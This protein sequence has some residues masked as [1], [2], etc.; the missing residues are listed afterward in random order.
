MAKLLTVS[1]GGLVGQKRPKAPPAARH[2]RRRRRHRK[3]EKLPEA[4]RREDWVAHPQRGVLESGRQRGR[5]RGGSGGK[6]GLGASGADFLAGR[7]A[8]IAARAGSQSAAL[9]AG[10]NG[11]DEAYTEEEVALGGRTRGSGRRDA[12]HLFARA[13]RAEGRAQ[14]RGAVLLLL[15]SMLSASCAT[16]GLKPWPPPQQSEAPVVFILFRSQCDGDCPSYRISVRQDGVLE[17]EG[18]HRVAELGHRWSQLSLEQVNMLT[19]MAFENDPKRNSID[20]LTTRG[21]E[22]GPPT[23]TVVVKTD[24]EERAICGSKKAVTQIGDAALDILRARQWVSPTPV[25]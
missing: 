8:L 17:Y 19:Q 25:R 20:H 15:S 10:D 5:G 18:L 7:L 3:T 16:T 6:H 4:E 11:D 1:I 21:C 24:A 23:I 14:A 22:F 2:S 12:S 13:D 9:G